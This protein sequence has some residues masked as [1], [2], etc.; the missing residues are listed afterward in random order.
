M[1]WAIVKISL[2]LSDPYQLKISE[3]DQFITKAACVQE[4]NQRNAKVKRPDYMCIPV[5]PD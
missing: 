2:F 4:V 5:D 1:F 3:K